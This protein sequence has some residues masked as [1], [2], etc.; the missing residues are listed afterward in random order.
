MNEATDVALNNNVTAMPELLGFNGS[1]N[2]ESRVEQ[3]KGG[4]E[5]EGDDGSSS[6]SSSSSSFHFTKFDGDGGGG[7]LQRETIPYHLFME[8][9]EFYF[10]FA[11]VI[12][13]VSV[14]CNLFIIIQILRYRNSF[15][16]YNLLAYSLIPSTTLLDHACRYSR[17]RST[18]INLLICFCCASVLVLVLAHL[19]LLHSGNTPLCLSTYLIFPG[20]VLFQK[21]MLSA[22]AVVRYLFIFG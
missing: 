15:F 18:T 6:S 9:V 17:R 14:P 19:S 4:S 3:I 21:L 8:D 16:G 13:L 1:D 20:A 12:I 5:D 22:M 2:N 10:T 11:I 7:G